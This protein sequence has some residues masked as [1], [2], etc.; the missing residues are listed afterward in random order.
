MFIS[1]LF[2]MLI[3]LRLHDLPNAFRNN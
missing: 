2:Q 1:L 3:C